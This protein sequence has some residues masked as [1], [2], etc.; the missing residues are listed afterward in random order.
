MISPS[1]PEP[2][3]WFW[4]NVLGED[5]NSQITRLENVSTRPVD[6]FFLQ[7]FSWQKKEK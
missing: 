7:D 3:Q 1:D 2:D 6:L 4:Y 5:T